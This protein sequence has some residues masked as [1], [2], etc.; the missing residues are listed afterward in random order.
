M[1]YLSNQKQFSGIINVH[2]RH[3]ACIYVHLFFVLK[4]NM[5][6]LFIRI[7][8][9]VLGVVHLAGAIYSLVATLDTEIY[10]TYF[11]IHYP[12]RIWVDCKNM[13]HEQINVKND[14]V[15]QNSIRVWCNATK[16][17]RAM[18][19]TNNIWF[20]FPF[21][22]LLVA[23]FAW[24][25]LFHFI[26]TTIYW[27]HY[28]EVINE[29]KRLRIRWFEYAHS[30]AVLF[31]IFSY[32]FGHTNIVIIT[33]LTLLIYFVVLTPFITKPEGNVTIYVSIS[34]TYVKVWL[35][36]IKTFFI[37]NWNYLEN[38]PWFVYVILIGEFI[39]FNSFPLVFVYEYYAIKR[40]KNRLYKIETTY[41]LLS[42]I[43]KLLTGAVFVFFFLFL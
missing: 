27:N 35:Y 28:I 6:E 16:S 39:L 15:M 13:L 38:V 34:L 29:G 9:L 23:Y 18:T 24:T 31:F 36:L 25:A 19:Y 26:Y 14:I 43:S 7:Q 42:V 5:G 8:G 30:S 1:C 37:D 17:E 33:G 22:W 32:L 11:P 21:G 4:K 41:N 10:N 12:E 40:N 2:T 20:D 3:K